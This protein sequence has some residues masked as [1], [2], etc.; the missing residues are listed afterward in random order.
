MSRNLSTTL[1]CRRRV[2]DPMRVYDGLPTPLR[3][4]L[5]QAA[6]PWSPASCLRIWRTARGR[7][8][9]V[10]AILARLDRAERKALHRDRQ[11]GRSEAV[12]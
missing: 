8:E 9:P 11:A 2:S 5:S 1:G 4:W 10:P 3:H 12:T 6:L 7:G